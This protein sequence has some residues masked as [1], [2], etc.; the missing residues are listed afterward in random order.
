VVEPLAAFPAAVKGRASA[1]AT[2]TLAAK[3]IREAEAAWVGFSGQ[4]AIAGLTSGRLLS[5]ADGSSLTLARYGIVPGVEVSGTLR[6]IAAGAPLAF[7]GTVTVSGRA[8]A[9][10]KLQVFAATI[11]GTLGGRRVASG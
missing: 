7:R 8:A 9:R 4:R 2:L 11:K 3:T 10:G 6:P 1:R 5:P